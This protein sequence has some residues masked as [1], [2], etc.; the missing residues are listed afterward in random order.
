M[1]AE[2]AQI[3]GLLSAFSSGRKLEETANIVEFLEWLTEHN[4]VDIRKLI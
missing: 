1:I 4:H 3:V 2:Y